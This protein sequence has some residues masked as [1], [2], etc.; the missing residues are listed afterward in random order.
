M[1]A[2]RIYGDQHRFI[3]VLAAH[4]GYRIAEIE[5]RHRARRH[6]RSKYGFSRLPKG[7]LDLGTIM[8]RTRYSGRPAHAFG[9]AAALCAAVS[10]ILLA[11]SGPGALPPALAAVSFAKGIVLACGAAAFLAAGWLAE[12]SLA[13]APGD[14]SALSACI[15]EVRD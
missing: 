5:V 13:R 2:L 4:L 11:L 6:G 15:E 12:V 14:P 1:Q 9:L 8:L 10:V 7:L 3:P